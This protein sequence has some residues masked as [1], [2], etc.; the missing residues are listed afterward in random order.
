MKKYGTINAVKDTYFTTYNIISFESVKIKYNL[1]EFIDYYM[2]RKHKFNTGNQ[3]TISR[4]FK[5]IKESLGYLPLELEL[6][7]KIL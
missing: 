1:E 2:N 5:F 4:H 6:L 3:W 7:L